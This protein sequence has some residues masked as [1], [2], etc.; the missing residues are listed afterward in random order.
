MKRLFTLVL[1]LMMVLTSFALAETI[2]PNIPSDEVTEVVFWHTF[3]GD[4]EALLKSQ[5]D[6]FMVENPN[7]KVTMQFIEG[8]YNGVFTELNAARQAGVGVPALTVI[9]VPRLTS[10]TEDEVVVDLTPYIEAFA[11]EINFPDFYEGM[12]DMMNNG[13]YQ[14]ALPFGQS[15][16]V[17]FYNKTLIQELGLTFPTKNEE[18]DEFLKTVFE[19]TGK[20]ALEIW[21]DDNA[22]SYPMFTNAGAD[23]IDVQKNTT[24]M[25]TDEA[26]AIIKQIRS[27]VDNGW[28][29]W[30]SE[31]SSKTLLPDF[32]SKATASILATSSSYSTYK[33]TA[34]SGQNA[35]D[36][37]GFEVGI[38]NQL[39]GS[40]GTNVQ[41]V[42]GATLIIPNS[43]F[44]TQY[45]KNAA[46]K[47]I[48]YLTNP[49]QQLAWATTSSY[50]ITR[51]SSSTDPQYA[52]SYAALLEQLPEM[53]N[54]DLNSYVAKTKH[55]LF[56]KCGDI[57]E[58]YMSEIMNNGMDPEE[59]WNAMCDEID[60]AL[61][62][63]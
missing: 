43:D 39:Y 27:W 36:G 11:D 16:Q 58:R 50:Y 19:A 52:K 10:F 22:Y 59:G 57:Y 45:Q 20:P 55:A 37:V 23:I 2:D 3:N 41:Y 35:E 60:E 31:S 49:T 13:G 8:G 32:T 53:A 40:A 28:V 42:A 14:T 61:A 12:V 17:F 54:L 7:I 9:N 44:T 48:C 46:F 4:N 26:L 51:K 6:A 29:K 18:M 33:K 1:A 30:I 34:A 25:R 5:V 47:L 24:G 63:M 21:A 38:A 15:G 62:D 56:D